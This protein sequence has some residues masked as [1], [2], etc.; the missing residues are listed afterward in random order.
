[1]RLTIN[2]QARLRRHARNMGTLNRKHLFVILKQFRII[3]LIISLILP[4]YPSFA[5][6]SNPDMS[7]AADYDASS[8]IM[9]YQGDSMDDSSVFSQNA[10]FIQPTSL[11]DDSRDVSGLDHVFT[12]QVH[13]GDTIG[14]IADKFN[15]TVSSISWANDIDPSSTLKTGTKLRIPPVS[16]LVYKVANGDTIQAIAN[17][18]HVDAG[19][20][21]DQNHLDPT[22]GLLAGQDIIVPGAH[23]LVTA[24]TVS[25]PAP[26]PTPVPVLVQAPQPVPAETPKPKPVPKKV[27]HSQPS[28]DTSNTSN[29]DSN[30][31]NSNNNDTPDGHHYAIGYTGGGGSF[32]FGNCTYYVANHKHVTWRGNASQWLANA[33]AA[34]VPTGSDPVIGAIVSFQGSGY[35]RYY[36]HVGIVVDVDGDDII[37]KDMNYRAFNEVTVRRV[38][39]DDP[40]IRGYIYTD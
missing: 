7:A 1:M 24:E 22:K 34:G 28:E 32:A 38:S 17:Q 5:S 26:T 21:I 20:I 13:N 37:V 15:V 30:T 31:D 18:Y 29:S 36:G 19:K 35:N 12:Y 8:I 25:A 40:A 2:V 27:R 9:S 11:I 16:G 4:I 33:A 14:G 3:A 39:K 6:L 10:G 23:P